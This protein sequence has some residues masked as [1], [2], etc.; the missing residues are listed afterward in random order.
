[1]T[2]PWLYQAK[3]FREWLLERLRGTS[4]AHRAIP[5]H[6]LD[7]LA[8]SLGL[9]TDV[10]VEA[11]ILAK[12]ERREQGLQIPRVH[13]SRDPSEFRRFYQYH[14]PF[15]VELWK[16]WK[17]ECEMRELKGS[18]LLR[19]V[20]HDYLSSA[21]DVHPAQ[22]WRFRGCTYKVPAGK[23]RGPYF[24]RATIPHG[25]KRALMRR[26]QLLGA[27]PLMVVRAL[28]LEVL[29]GAHRNVRLIQSS[30]MY[31][32]ENRYFEAYERAARDKALTGAE[33]GR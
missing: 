4:W 33:S 11:R 24:E 5:D 32:D 13:T 12:I 29:S 15:P 10:L 27:R 21:R 6:K 2:D 23:A 8:E 18:V 9:S 16:L 22:W 19:S 30:M 26:A 25:A 3:S 1:M 28:V 14:V 31:D 17:D 7:A 20:I